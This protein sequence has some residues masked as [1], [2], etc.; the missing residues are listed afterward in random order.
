VWKNVLNFQVFFK[1][2][3]VLPFLF[4]WLVF[5]YEISNIFQSYSKPFPFACF[6]LNYTTSS[7]MFVL[8]RK[9]SSLFSSLFKPTNDQSYFSTVV[10][11]V[12]W[13]Y[14]DGM[15]GV[16]L[17]ATTLDCRVEFRVERNAMV[18]RPEKI[19]R[20]K[21]SKFLKYSK[22][23]KRLQLRLLHHIAFK[24]KLDCLFF[25]W[26]TMVNSFKMLRNAKN[27]WPVFPL[28]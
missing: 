3:F 11:I 26:Q 22:V 18:S 23:E 6:P 20:Q 7:L 27:T 13:S 25:V 19:V 14:F 2:S 1:F 4:L 10:V 21:L 16:V 9:W 5:F 24:K 15:K 8:A 17:K 12:E 28:K